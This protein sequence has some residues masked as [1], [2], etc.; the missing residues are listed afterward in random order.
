MKKIYVVVTFTAVLMGATLLL[1][2]TIRVVA[3][4]S[5]TG[6]KNMVLAREAIS[7]AAGDSNYVRVQVL[8]PINVLNREKQRGFRTD[9]HRWHRGG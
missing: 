9:R 7:N 3:A 5:P 8:T 1:E 2:R 4:A 6:I